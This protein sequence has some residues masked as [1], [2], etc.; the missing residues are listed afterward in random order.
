LEGVP[1]GLQEKAPLALWTRPKPTTSVTHGGGQQ[2]SPFP[3]GSRL[4]GQ[5]STAMS[6]L[7]SDGHGGTVVTD[8]LV[9]SSEHAALFAAQA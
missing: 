1:S 4:L 8:P 5:Y 6:S 7:A 3:G 9:G 2:Q